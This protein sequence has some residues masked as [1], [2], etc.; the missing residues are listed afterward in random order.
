MIRSRFL[1]SSVLALSA[2]AALS[3][4]DTSPTGPSP[5]PVSSIRAGT[6]QNSLLGGLLSLVT[7]VV[8]FVADATGLTVHPIAW[9]SSYAPVSY[10]VSGTI[11]SWG[12]TLTIPESDFTIT[13]PMGAVSQP[14]LITITSDPGYVAYKMQPAGIKFAK[15]VLVTQRLR[16]TAIYGQPLTT[17]LFGAYISDDTLDLSKL[18]HVLEIELSTTIFQSGSSSYPEIET[19]TVNHFSRYML[20]SD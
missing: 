20:A 6:A 1:R 19:W 3:C 7:S 5:A 12:G 14:T 13:F 15:P 17:Q 8:G 16:K 11:T 9:N 4:A 10:T 2:F 18:L